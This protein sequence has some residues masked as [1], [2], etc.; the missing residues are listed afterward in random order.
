VPKVRSRPIVR[1]EP[2]DP[3]TL[4][5]TPALF[6]W[7]SRRFAPGEATMLV[8]PARP[9]ESLLELLYAGVVST[10]GRISLLEGANRF[11]PYR[12]GER[13]RS[14]GTDPSTALESVRLARAFTAYQM[15]ALLEG[16][17]HEVRRHPPTLLV[18]HEVPALFFESEFPPEE[19]GPLLAHAARTLAD[20]VRSTRR[21]LL[22]TSVTGLTAF[23]GL[24]EEGPRLFDLVRVTPD[25]G[26][27]ALEAYREATHLS[28]V[29][30]PDGQRGLE[31]FGGPVAGEVTPWDGRSRRTGRPSRSG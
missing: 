27:L 9:V 28:M 29:R 20:L 8:G 7:L 23:P 21:S 15:I 31:E 11:H 22:V 12:I 24:A 5:E 2:V 14:L 17:A 19:R 30:R 10:G 18:A 4:P 1:P 13:A 25:D 16:W 26:G 3:L 6:P